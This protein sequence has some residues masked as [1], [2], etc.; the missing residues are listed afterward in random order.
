[1]PQPSNWPA[2][3]AY[4]QRNVYSKGMDAAALK[5]IGHTP[6][7]PG[8]PQQVCKLV[9]IKKITDPKHPAYNQYGLFAAKK[10][11]PRTHL[12][13][14]LGYVHT[15]A[16]SDES[17]NYDI[18]LDKDTGIAIDA[19]RCGC[20]ARMV[21]DYRGICERPNVQFDDR[22]VG[23]ELRIAIFTMSEPISAGTELCINYGKGFW[24]ARQN[25]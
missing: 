8:P 23:D 24:N 10:I 13:D 16:E 22:Y 3:I 12:L 6:Q 21:N 15:A 4:I 20:E 17:S 25:S 18:V 2:D 14:Y 1:M 11:P 5:V 19:Q 7:W 9:K